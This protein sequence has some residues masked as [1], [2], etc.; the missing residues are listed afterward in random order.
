MIRFGILLFA[1]MSI[2]AAQG[3][4]SDY[5]DFV[6][7]VSD[8]CG[9]PTRFDSGFTNTVARFKRSLTNDLEVASAELAQ[10]LFFWHLYDKMGDCS[11][12]ELHQNQVSNI[13][14]NVNISTNSWV[15]QAAAFQYACGLNADGKYDNSYTVVTNAIREISIGGLDMGSTSFWPAISASSCETRIAIHEALKV[16]AA[17]EMLRRDDTIGVE[18]YTN[19]LSSAACQIFLEEAE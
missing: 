17:L 9:N 5:Y 10:G 7:Y 13:L 12:F 19:G 3:E 8:V 4:I 14:E 11:A 2:F 1:S 6:S 18:S 16:I 15:R